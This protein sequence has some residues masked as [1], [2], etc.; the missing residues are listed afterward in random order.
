MITLGKRVAAT[1]R[2]AWYGPEST[3][4]GIGFGALEASPP[5]PCE[6]DDCLLFQVTHSRHPGAAHIR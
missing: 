4:T 2:T 3:P 1:G 6:M 5:Q